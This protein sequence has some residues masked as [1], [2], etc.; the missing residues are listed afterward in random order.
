MTQGD[1][2]KLIAEKHNVPVNVVEQI[3]RSQCELL[4]K[5][6][7]EGDKKNSKSFKTILIVGLGKFVPLTKRI[8]KLTFK[9]KNETSD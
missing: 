7:A 5:T 3:H 9:E 4:R 1:I 8:D 6:L 2:M